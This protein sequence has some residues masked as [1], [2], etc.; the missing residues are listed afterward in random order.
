MT[1]AMLAALVLFIL[2]RRFIAACVLAAIAA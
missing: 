2:V 1:A